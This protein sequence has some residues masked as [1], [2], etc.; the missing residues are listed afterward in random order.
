MNNSSK[1]LLLALAAF[2]AG[3]F[4]S[5]HLYPSLFG[6]KYSEQCVVGLRTATTLTVQACLRL[7]PSIRDGK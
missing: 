6:Y 4:I 7:Y 5:P 3:F 2:L 1:T